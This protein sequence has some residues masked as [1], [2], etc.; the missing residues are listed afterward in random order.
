MIRNGQPRIFHPG[1]QSQS[2]SITKV[3]LL[4]I[5]IFHVY[6]GKNTASAN[7]RIVRETKTLIFKKI[8]MLKFEN[9]KNVFHKLNLKCKWNRPWVSNH[10]SSVTDAFLKISRC[11]SDRAR[12][13]CC[14]ISS[15]TAAVTQY[16]DK[17]RM[18]QLT[19]FMY[20]MNVKWR[21]DDR[22]PS[23]FPDTLLP[24]ICHTYC[25]VFWI[26]CTQPIS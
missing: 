21:G 18:R 16:Q 17:S 13:V 7:E 15:S 9:Q 14:R 8:S 26:H 20:A 19:V 10:N 12:R 4:T 5:V 11:S 24:K 1:S 25:S 6:Y 23:V 2:K 3:F 22:I